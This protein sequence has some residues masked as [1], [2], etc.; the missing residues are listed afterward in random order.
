MI[1]SPMSHVSL[2]SAVPVSNVLEPSIRTEW[3]AMLILALWF[4]AVAMAVGV[5]RDIPVIDDWT[6]AW[7]VE[8]LFVDGRIEVLD[9]SAVYPLAHSL[10]GAAWSLV[11]GFSFT[12]LRLSTLA[13]SLLATCALYLILR[14]LE[15]R[16]PIALLGALTVAANPVVLLLSSSFMTDVPFVASTLMALLCYMRAMRR[17]QVHLVWWGGAWACLAFLD[18]QVAIVTPMAALPLLMPRPSGEPKRSAVLW[19]LGATWGAMLVSSLV[20][21]SLVRP[22]GEM[23]K[24]VDR[25]Q[26]LLTIPVTRYLTSNL[27]VLSTIAFYALPALLAMATVRRLWRRPALFVFTLSLA[28]IM[29][30]LA[31]EIPVPLRPG[32]TWT[33]VEVGGSRGL[34]NG[35]LPPSERTT[36]EIILRGAGLLAFGLVLMSLTWPESHSGR[37]RT[38]SAW[39]PVFRRLLDTTNT[40]SMTPRMPLII[41]LIAYLL[42]ANVLWMYNDRYLIVLLPVVVALALGGRQH[43]ADVPRLAWI[44]VA[45]FA[46][47]AVVGTRDALRFNQSLRDGWQALVDSGVRPSDIDAG[48]AWNGWWLYAHPENLAGGLTVQDVPWITSQRHPTYILSMSALPGYDVARE[49]AWTDDAPWPGPDR[50]LVLKR[51]APH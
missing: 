21:M 35:Q 29:L 43:G 26:D 36:I 19:A 37:A 17:G 38:A 4:V 18:R 9:W 7:S 45:I 31:G 8:R 47:V 1:V 14:E 13:L 3:R 30:V 20:M 10:W 25:L 32:N 5:Y 42:I 46:T 28:A 49:V 39:R 44:A 33:L 27:Y 11:L 34:V 12:T 40:I 51:Q 16:P 22:T 23:L 2:E 50:L 24:L 6:Y 48:Y 15:A 41:Y